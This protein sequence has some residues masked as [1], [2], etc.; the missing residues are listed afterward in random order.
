M[1]IVVVAR[2][3]ERDGKREN[4]S[5]YPSRLSHSP[6]APENEGQAGGVDDLVMRIIDVVGGCPKMG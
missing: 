1:P 4:F 5:S 6:L 2:L 3:P